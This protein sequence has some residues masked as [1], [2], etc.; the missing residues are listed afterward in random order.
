MGFRAWRHSGPSLLQTRLHK[1]RRDYKNALQD[2]QQEVLTFDPGGH[3]C[4]KRGINMCL[5]QMMLLSHFE[6]PCVHPDHTPRTAGGP[7]A[8]CCSRRGLERPRLE[9]WTWMPGCRQPLDPTPK[10]TTPRP[11]ATTPSALVGA[12]E[13]K[14]DTSTAGH[15][16]KSGIF[17][18]T[19]V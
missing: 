18:Y 5:L 7:E 9:R 13:Y 4:F 16:M 14:S 11:P 8:R 10:T 15:E 12:S 6:A 3:M 17:V 1:A 2:H 19:E